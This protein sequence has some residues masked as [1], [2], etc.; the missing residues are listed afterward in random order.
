M[1]KGFF[2]FLLISFGINSEPVFPIKKIIGKGLSKPGGWQYISDAANSPSGQ[3]YHFYNNVSPTDS[4]TVIRESIYR[5]GDEEYAFIVHNGDS[6]SHATFSEECIQAYRTERM[7]EYAKQQ[8]ETFKN[9]LDVQL[10]EALLQ[11]L[12]R[13]W[14]YVYKYRGEYYLNRVWYSRVHAIEFGKGVI[15]GI[16]MEI[17][18]QLM[19]EFS[20]D[21]EHFKVRL[22]HRELNFTRID[23]E[24]EIYRR[25]DGGY[26]IPAR[27]V[28]DFKL[29]AYCNNSGD[30]CTSREEFDKE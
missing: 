11:K 17:I 23:K 15:M 2:I 26:M 30:M 29:I 13:F 5:D 1:L 18:P 16:N 19:L 12:G 27:R 24:R 21:I 28:R 10:D 6:D 4:L 22:K 25:S 3:Q 8:L 14:V 9:R 7:D 20:G